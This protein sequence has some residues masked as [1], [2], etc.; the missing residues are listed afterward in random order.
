MVN[1]IEHFALIVKDIFLCLPASIQAMFYFVIAFI[2]LVG[3]I[4]LIFR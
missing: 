3:V 4:K 2:V 1:T